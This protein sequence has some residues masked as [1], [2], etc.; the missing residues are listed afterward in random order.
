MMQMHH[1]KTESPLLG[2]STLAERI[3]MIAHMFMTAATIVTTI[4]MG[5]FF[6][7]KAK[8]AINQR[9]MTVIPTNKLLGNT[10]VH[11]L[12]LKNKKFDILDER[13]IDIAAI[14]KNDFIRVNAGQIVLVDS[15]IINGQVDVI[16]T[17]TF[18][19]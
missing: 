12:V 10:K 6:E 8:K 16:E 3:L 18:G 9:V 14:E 11:R 1:M 4:I 19:E 7:N 15:T 5:K 17:I 2:N 13:V